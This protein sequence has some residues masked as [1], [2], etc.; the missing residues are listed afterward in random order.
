M[1]NNLIF[2]RL[3]PEEDLLRHSIEMWGTKRAATQQ[4]FDADRFTDFN[5]TTMNLIPQTMQEH[6][7]KLVIDVTAEN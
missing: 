4:L 6:V 2:Y 1:A 3:I 5:A 7:G